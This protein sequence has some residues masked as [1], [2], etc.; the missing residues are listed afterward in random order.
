MSYLHKLSEGMN[1]LTL[2]IKDIMKTMRELKKSSVIAYEMLKLLSDGKESS[3]VSAMTSNFFSKKIFHIKH[4]K[5]TILFG[6][7][8]FGII[9]S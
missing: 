9:K 3:T 5:F 2:H 4:L 7:M 6:S 8:I 1:V